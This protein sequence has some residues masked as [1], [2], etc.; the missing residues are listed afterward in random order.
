MP[1]NPVR[2]LTVS[3]VGPRRTQAPTAASPT[4]ASTYYPGYPTY[5]GY[6]SY[7][8]QPGPN[9]GNG[10]SNIFR[11]IGE[12]LLVTAQAAGTL[13]RWAGSAAVAILSVAWQLIATVGQALGRG[14]RAIFDPG[15]GYQPG[16]PTYPNYP[17]Y[18]RY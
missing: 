5:P 11:G 8:V 6:P 18:P 15:Y 16:Y 9:L 13:L 7:P 17:T 1:L 14:L 10:L 3:P 12:V 4:P 2:P